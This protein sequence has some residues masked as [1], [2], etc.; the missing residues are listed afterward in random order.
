MSATTTLATELMT[1]AARESTSAVFSMMVNM[2]I[3]ALEAFEDPNPPAFDGVVALLAFNGAWIGS[4]MVCCH[5]R[6]ACLVSS[7]MLG[8]E[9]KKVDDDVLDGM[10]E[11]ANM[12]LGNVKECLESHTGAL[13]LSIPTV[14]WGKNY[15]A[16][17]G[18]RAP[19][20]VQPFQ[21]GKDV[22][23]VRLCMKRG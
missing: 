15:S 21:I 18:I 19:W 4:G 3:T 9:L 6:L 22:F 8:H 10:G 13:S 23:E 2:D 7:A 16:R 17:S 12:V 5:E 14:L 11:I 1:E 20:V